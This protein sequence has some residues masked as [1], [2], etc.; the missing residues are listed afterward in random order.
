MAAKPMPITI[1]AKPYY[2]SK[3]LCKYNPEFYYG[4]KVKPR[5][6]IQKK[7]IPTTDYI[8]ANL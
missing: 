6:I 5:N 3:D 4:C 7:K 8:Y 1:D 2:N